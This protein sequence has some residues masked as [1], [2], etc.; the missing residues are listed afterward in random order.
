MNPTDLPSRS[1]LKY[2]RSNRRKTTIYRPKVQN[3]RKISAI[4]SFWLGSRKFKNC[5]IQFTVHSFHCVF[6][7]FF[8]FFWKI[9]EKNEYFWICLEI[10][11]KFWD[12]F[13]TFLED[14]GKIF[15][16][17]GKFWKIFGK[18]WKTKENQGKPWKTKE[19]HKFHSQKFAVFTVTPPRP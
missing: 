6:L 5:V 8:G 15:D 1:K 19:N 4:I 16:I 9:L 18:F 13:G 10:F 7:E 17:F 12:I 11:G 14:F 2:S 3:N